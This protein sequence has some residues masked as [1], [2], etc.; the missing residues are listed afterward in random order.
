MSQLKGLVY[1]GIAGVALVYSKG[2]KADTL[3]KY[4]LTD[5]HQPVY[6]SCMLTMKNTKSEFK[7]G[8]TDYKGCACMAKYAVSEFEGAQLPAYNDMFRSIV[9]TAKKT[10]DTRD[11]SK[12]NVYQNDMVTEFMTLST[13]HG[14]EMSTTFT[15]TDKLGDHL[16]TCGQSATHRDAALSKIVA[17]PVKGAPAKLVPTA[18]E[19]AASVVS[20]RGTSDPKK[21]ASKR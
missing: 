1:L 4:E 16:S 8:A 5:T 11:S 2:L 12:K 17:L 15:M 6:Q 10:R 19:P 13:K 20:L 14:L 7:D 21:S 18:K 3:K 9:T